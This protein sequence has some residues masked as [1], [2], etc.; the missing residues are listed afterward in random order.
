M[1]A[2]EWFDELPVVTKYFVIISAVMPIAMKLNL[3]PPSLLVWHLKSI[4]SRFEVYAFTV[5]GFFCFNYNLLL[6]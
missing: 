6:F 5:F 3:L 1:S 4:T 2:R